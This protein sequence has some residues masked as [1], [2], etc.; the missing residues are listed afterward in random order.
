MSA[1]EQDKKKVAKEIAQPNSVFRA[2]TAIGS[3]VWAGGSGA[4]LFHSDDFG[5]HWTRL[6][7]SSA[8]RVLNG[9]IMVI[10][11]SDAQ[12]GKIATSYGELWVTADNGKTWSLQP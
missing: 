1:G 4:M 7:P 10:E 11:F 2:V 9:D 5:A 8:S 3:D 6:L 12:H